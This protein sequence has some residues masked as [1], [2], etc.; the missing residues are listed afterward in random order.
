[1]SGWNEQMDPEDVDE[2]EPLVAPGTTSLLQS[3]TRLQRMERGRPLG[4]R[5]KRPMVRRAY[6]SIRWYCNNGPIMTVMAIYQL[7]GGI[8]DDSTSMAAIRTLITEEIASLATVAY[9]CNQ[10]ALSD[11]LALFPR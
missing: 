9:T 11:F 8:F 2:P 5:E 3:I 1:M 7:V 6:T 10:E 4:F